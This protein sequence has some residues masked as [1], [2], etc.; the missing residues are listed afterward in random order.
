MRVFVYGSLM[1]GLHNHDRFLA[2]AEFVRRDRTRHGNYLL[3]S[4][5]AYPAAVESNGGGYV[6]GEVY[7]VGADTLAALDRLEGHPV[8]YERQAVSL[9]YGE[10]A[11][12]Y[13]QPSEQVCGPRRHGVVPSGNWRDVAGFP[14]GTQR[15]ES[16][17]GHGLGDEP[18]PGVGYAACPD[19][20]GLG[21]VEAKAAAA[22]SGEVHTDLF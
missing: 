6:Y 3:F 1:K 12:M 10:K 19:C 20:D 4:V 7:A 18:E 9:A 21:H 15:C 16:C 14:E 2:K 13:L 11:W 8:H 5:G 22:S 17:G